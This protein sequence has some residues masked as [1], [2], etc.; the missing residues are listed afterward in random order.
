MTNFNYWIE[1]TDRVWIKVPSIPENDSITI[2][3][4]KTGDYSPSGDDTFPF[5]DDFSGSSLDTDKWDVAYNYGD[6]SVANDKVTLF[7]ANI[8]SKNNFGKGFSV[9]GH[10]RCTT[11]IDYPGI[12]T[13]FNAPRD[14][15]DDDAL[16]VYALWDGFRANPGRN[17][18]RAIKDTSVNTIVDFDSDYYADSTWYITEIQNI[19]NDLV[20]GIWQEGSSIETKSYTDS[21]NIPTVNM[22]ACIGTRGDSDSNGNTEG[23]WFWVFVRKIVEDEPSISVTDQ[24]THYE[25]TINNTGGDELTDYQISV[26]ASDLG[27]L[28]NDESLEIKICFK[29]KGT[30]KKQGTLIQGAKVSCINQDTNELVGHTTSDENGEW[31]FLD[32]DD[33]SKY[34]VVGS[35]EDGEDKFNHL[36]FYDLVPKEEEQ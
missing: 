5:F 4:K 6:I 22:N 3:V 18:V 26:S 7:R 20:T 23:E 30:T 16:S 24:T 10:W 17:W 27:T 11:D 9:R 29:I 32:L 14:E 12:W 28:A 13:G 8:K 2:N 34:H 1:E 25:V 33:E 35:L 31:E 15:H 19:A 21:N 36:S